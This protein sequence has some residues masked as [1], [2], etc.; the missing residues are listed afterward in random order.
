MEKMDLTSRDTLMKSLPHG[1]TGAEIGVQ[2]G[3]FAKSILFQ[4]EPSRLFLIDC[5]EHQDPEVYGHD[6]A[7]A[8]D[9]A[10]LIYFWQVQAAFVQHRNV[11]VLRMY[12]QDA[13]QVFADGYFDWIYLDANHLQVGE[14][15]DAWY[16]KVKPGGWCAGLKSINVSPYWAL[17]YT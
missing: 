3:D 6:P 14:D 9:M 1:G 16:P 8:P 12:S 17:S 4:N 7:N 13:V 2:W 11:H 15:I 5:W 10:H